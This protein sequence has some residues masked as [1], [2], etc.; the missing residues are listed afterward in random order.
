M[1]MKCTCPASK[2][3][4]AAYQ[5]KKYGAGNRVFT[6]AD[7]GKKSHCTVCSAIYVNDK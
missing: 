2:S 1:I 3:D 4:A 6:E 5:D 7:K